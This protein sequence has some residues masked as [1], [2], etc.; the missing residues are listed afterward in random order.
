MAHG[1]A[2]EHHWVRESASIWVWGAGVWMSALGLQRITRGA[3]LIF[4]ISYPL[5]AMRI[6]RRARQ[7][8]WSESDAQLYAL[9]CVLGKFPQLQGQFIFLLNHLRGRATHLDSILKT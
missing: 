5:L 1:A 9:F 6:Y 4:L 2:P 3:S 7:R 8:G